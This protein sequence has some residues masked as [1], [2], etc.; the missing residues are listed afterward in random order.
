MKNYEVVEGRAGMDLSE[1]VKQFGHYSYTG[2]MDKLEFN[3]DW[4]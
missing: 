4:L 3:G 1:V 2:K